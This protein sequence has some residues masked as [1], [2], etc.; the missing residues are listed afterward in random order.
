MAPTPSTAGP[1][2][3]ELAASAATIA[4]ALGAQAIALETPNAGIDHHGSGRNWNGQ[5]YVATPQLLKA[6]G[7]KES[8]IQP[9]ADILTARP[10]L[11]GVSGLGLTTAATEKATA[12]AT[13]AAT[14]TGRNVVGQLF[15]GLFG[16]HGLSRQ[17]GHP[18]GGRP[19]RGD[20]GT[21]HGHH[22]ARH[23][24]VPHPGEHD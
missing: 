11:S 22:R 4:G 10:G 23:A 19:S 18:R 20:V 17:P 1:S 24:K 7:I 2:P 14:E 8:E 13:A 9:N 16:R 15:V 6:F 5:I 3:A 21:E 12:T